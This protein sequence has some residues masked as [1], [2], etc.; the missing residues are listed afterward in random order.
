MHLEGAYYHS[1]LIRI[2]TLRSLQKVMQP[3]TQQSDP[4]TNPVENGNPE[5]FLVE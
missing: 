1:N 2:I 3:I 5:T 4:K